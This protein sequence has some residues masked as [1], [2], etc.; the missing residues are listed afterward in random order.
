M[1]GDAIPQCPIKVMLSSTKSIGLQLP[2]QSDITLDQVKQTLA[3]SLSHLSDVVLDQVKA[4][5][6]LITEQ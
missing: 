6:Y 1:R 3:A 5:F 4:P 2:H